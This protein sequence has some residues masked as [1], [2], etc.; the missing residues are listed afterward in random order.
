M[1]EIAAIPTEYAGVQFRSRLEARWAAFFDLLDLSWEYEPIDLDGYIPDF[2]LT[3]SPLSARPVLVEVKPIVQWPCPVLRCMDCFDAPRGMYD[4]AV[5]K[6]EASGWTDAAILVG[7]VPLHDKHGWFCWGRHVSC[8][9]TF[10]YGA[11]VDLPGR[12]DTQRQLWREAGN[13][14]QWRKTG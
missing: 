8:N 3:K 6:I 1:N 13:A 12:E 10:L 4:D 7:A 2:L 5:A 14:V 11:L 9:D